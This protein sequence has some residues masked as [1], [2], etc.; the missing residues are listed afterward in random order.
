MKAIADAEAKIT[1][2]TTT[3]VELAAASIR[4]HTEIVNPEAPV[5]VKHAATND[6]GKMEAVTDAEA[7]IDDLM[8]AI[9]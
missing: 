4:Q 8:T 3:I 1:D 5:L 6:K 7:K 2:L 9:K